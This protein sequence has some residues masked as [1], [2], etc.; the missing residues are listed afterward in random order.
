MKKLLLYYYI[1]TCILLKLS[2]VAFAQDFLPALN[3]NYMGINQAGLQPAAIVDSRLKIDINLFG[4]NSDIY[5]DMLRFKTSGIT[6]PFALFTEDN[7]FDNNVY[8]DELDGSDKNAIINQTILGPSV[9]ITIN[10]KNAIGLTT[11]F[12]HMANVDDVSEALAV[13][14]YDDFKNPDYWNTWYHDE[15]I[16]AV[17]NIFADYGLT[18]AREIMNTGA[19]YLKTGI[20]L[21]L[22]QGLGGAAMQADDFYYY[23]SAPGNNPTEA[24]SMSWNTPYAFMG[25]SDNFNWGT[26]PN[27][28]YPSDVNYQFTAKPSFGLDLGLVYEW[29]PDYEKY[30]YDMNGETNIDRADKNKYR[31]RVGASILDIGRL[32]YEKAYSST[33]FT[34][35]FTPD[36]LDRFNLGDNT[37]PVNTFWMNIEDVAL[38]FPPYVNLADTINNRIETDKGMTAGENNETEFI[39]KLPTAFSFQA[40][41]NVI[42]GLYVNLTTFT[43]LHQSFTETGNAHYLSNYSITP[44][45]EH[46]WFSVMLP[47]QYNQFQDF[48]MGLGVRAAF[49]YAG[50]NNLFT[51]LFNDPYGTNIYFGI[52]LPI[53]QDGPPADRDMDGVSDDMDKCIDQPGPWSLMGCPDR[54]NDGITDT[55]DRCPDVAGSAVFKGCPDTDG[56]GIADI[57]D[58]CPDVAG[59]AETGGCPDRDNDGVM[60]SQDECPDTPGLV[61]LNGCPDRDNDGVPDIRDNCP[62]EFGKAEYGG[63]PFLDTDGDGIKDEADAC[64]TVAGPP[65]NNGCPYSDTDGDGV[66]DRDD[67]CPLTPGEISNNGC[68]VLKEEEQE[69]LNF[70]FDNLEFETGKSIIRKSSYESLD[71]LANL[72]IRRPTWKLKISGHTDDVGNDA[73]NMTLSKNRTLATAK[74]LENKGVP[75]DR[76]VN[77][78]FGETKPIADNKTPEGR[79][80]NRRVEMVVVFD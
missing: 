74:Y 16:R 54:D 17:N 29:R 64:P 18:Y 6:N 63:C 40:D 34:S 49:I 20:T 65:E 4:L 9:M 11:K 80:K 19:H 51:G 76:F 22:V 44:R 39:I 73:S 66:I 53:W 31:L 23:F 33:D 47:I 13:S 67:K 30:R 59:P 46:Q 58:K 28:A 5:N 61:A 60:D 27:S 38:G 71:S 79:Q 57:D 8:I 72:L 35:A 48:N 2:G 37:Y 42:A 78:W 68:P 3:D 50:V 24:D 43:A 32:K 70:A 62:D 56:D 14:I 21:K 52:K 1:T 12:R 10:S 36:Y 55:E 25:V 7:W 26:A 77:E 45:Y 15:D 41:V 75:A 69:I